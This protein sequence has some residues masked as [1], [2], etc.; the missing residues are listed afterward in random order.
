[1]PRLGHTR[2]DQR[3]PAVGMGA[4]SP[5]SNAWLGRG[6]KSGG[7]MRRFSRRHIL[8]LAAYLG[9][10]GANVTFAVAQTATSASGARVALDGYDPLSYFEPG[11]PEKGSPKFQFAFDDAVYWFNSADHQAR[12]A[13][14][15]ER[16]APQ[17]GG[18]CATALAAGEKVEAD[19]HAWSISNGKLY[20]FGA[21][22]GVPEFKR[23][24]ESV[25]SQ[26]NS[27]WQRLREPKLALPS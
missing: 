17:Y 24:P 5:G 12:F 1:M 8:T 27:N 4:S 25:V 14:D 15:P 13:A 18:Y 6:E 9:T 7:S 11:R 26:A 16:Y 3:Q 19:P 22:E 2:Q 10:A 23:N 20:V 21:K